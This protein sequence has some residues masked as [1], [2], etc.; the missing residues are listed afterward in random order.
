MRSALRIPT[1]I[2]LHVAA[3]AVW[4]GNPAAPRRP[5]SAPLPA[6]SLTAGRADTLPLRHR[7][8]GGALVLG[9]DGLA[10]LALPGE[11][12]Y[13]GGQRFILRAVADAE[14]HVFVVAEGG[15]V[16]R[17]YWIQME[18][19]LP[20][21]A[22][23]YDYGKDAPVQLEGR[24]FRAQVRRYTTPPDPESDRGRLYAYLERAGYR[25]P[26]LALRARLVRVTTPDRRA[27]LMIIHAEA[28]STDGVPSAEEVAAAIERAR[29]GIRFT[30]ARSPGT[31]AAKRSGRRVAR[32]GRSSA[33]AHA[34]GACGRTTAGRGSGGEVCT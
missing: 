23:A 8:V 13:V 34:R 18:E 7:V 2:G 29:S 27:E 3:V 24:E 1:V 32:S 26:P 14:Q 9:L 21:A 25:V 17:F 15:D 19:Y 10:E 5:V 20:A 16:K 28:S 33:V 4:A 31:R 30:A 22:G 6:A 11:Y 12:R